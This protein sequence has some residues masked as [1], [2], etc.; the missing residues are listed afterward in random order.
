MSTAIPHTPIRPAVRVPFRVMAAFILIMSSVVVVGTAFFIGRGA[1][2]LTAGDILM[3]PLFAW[4][5][6]LALHAA[7]YGKTSQSGQEW[8]PFA[9]SSVWNCYTTLLIAYWWFKP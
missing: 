2:A 5:G 9:S 4:F 6:R 3:L 1:R 8:W 7:R